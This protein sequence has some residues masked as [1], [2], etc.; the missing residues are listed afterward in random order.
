[1]GRGVKEGN[2]KAFFSAVLIIVCI[3]FPITIIGAIMAGGADSLW[4][5]VAALV[6]Y[7]VKIKGDILLFPLSFIKVECPL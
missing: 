4:R 5:F 6:G 7:R 1:M 2:M 3:G